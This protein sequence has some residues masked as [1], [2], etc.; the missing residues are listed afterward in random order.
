MPDETLVNEYLAGRI[1]RRM[2]IRRLA[3]AGI[4]FGAAVSYAHLLDPERA[5]ARAAGGG[6]PGFPHVRCKIVEQDLD[7]VI[8]EERVKVRVSTSHR[9]QVEL[10]IDLLRP[11]G[12]YFRS[13][14]GERVKTFKRPL[15]KQAIYVPLAVNPPHSVDALRPLTSADLALTVIL[16]RLHAPPWGSFSHQRSLE[17]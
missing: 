14:I 12:P 11:S 3:A 15:K 9:G 13:R 7:R 5:P 6:H 10:A 8:D 1:S 17:R 2:L 16:R 4:S